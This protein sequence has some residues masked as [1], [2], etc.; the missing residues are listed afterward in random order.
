MWHAITDCCQHACYFVVLVR[1]R[2][3]QQ[4]AAYCRDCGAAWLTPA[5]YDNDDYKIGSQEFETGV[6]QPTVDE[7]ASSDWGSRVQETVDEVNFM[8]LAELNADL[9]E[10]SR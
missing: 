10:H 4:I 1:S 5:D 7:I 9:T 2:S 6:E 3:S 8:T